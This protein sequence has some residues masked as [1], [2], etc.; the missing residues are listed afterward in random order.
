MK[1]ATPG[2]RKATTVDGYLATLDADQRAALEKLRAQIHAAAP[3]CEECISYGMPAM[4]HSGRMLLWMGAG[5][6]HCALYPGAIVQEFLDELE[7]F[8]TSKGTI[9]FTPERPI[10]AALLRRL[11]QACVARNVARGGAR[12]GAA[13]QEGSK[14]RAA[15]KPRTAA[16]RG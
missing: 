9:R 10:P 16:R 4:K 12:Q 3:G 5:T 7:A 14:A 8:E 2:R 6:N 13:K 11:V 15:A 1:S